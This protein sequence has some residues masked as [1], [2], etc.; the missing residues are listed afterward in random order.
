[1]RAGLMA[2]GVFIAWGTVALAEGVKPAPNPSGDEEHA[3]GELTPR[4]TAPSAGRSSTVTG[5]SSGRSS[6]SGSSGWPDRS[7]TGVRRA[8]RFASEAR[9]LRWAGNGVRSDAMRG[10]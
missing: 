2:C 3:A 1:M 7:P 4:A 9:A 8:S 10:G 5:R 6:R